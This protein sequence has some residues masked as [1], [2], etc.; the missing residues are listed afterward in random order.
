MSGRRC[1]Q[2]ESWEPNADTNRFGT[3]IAELSNQFV[4]GKDEYPKDI[5]SACGMLVNYTASINTRPR[6][7]NT[8][9][10]APRAPATPAA[11]APPSVVPDTSAMT[12]AQV[13]SGAT[14]GVN[15]ITHEE[16]TCYHCTGMATTRPT[17]RTIER[18]R[19]HSDAG[20]LRPGADQ[21]ARY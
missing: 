12:Y 17:A 6:H 14:A 1:Q 3:L 10:A 16:I 20:R 8:H 15:G 2:T 9:S 5:T 4:R 19:H 18:R 21:C 11:S 7:I 13:Q